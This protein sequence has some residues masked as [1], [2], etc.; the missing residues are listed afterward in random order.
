MLS[1][2]E[3]ERLREIYQ[4]YA[5]KIFCFLQG[6]S[7]GNERISEEISQEV[8]VSLARMISE[9]ACWEEKQVLAWLRLMA[10]V[11]YRRY[12][13]RLERKQG[14]SLD[15]FLKDDRC[16]DDSMEEMVLLRIFYKEKFSE[17]T[18]MEKELVRCRI[19]GLSYKNRHPGEKR[20][21]NAL[22]IR[23]SRAFRK[24]RQR[25]KEEEPRYS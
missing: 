22:A 2:R 20:S 18:E 9:T 25:L 4:K 16:V 14:V 17:L 21:D 11:K 13:K 23:C 7:G 19:Y 24:W 3:E 15:E 1:L 8:W 5:E 6:L 10:R 12:M